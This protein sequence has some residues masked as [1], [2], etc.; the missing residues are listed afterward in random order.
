MRLLTRQQH[1]EDGVMNGSGLMQFGFTVESQ[2]PRIQNAFTLRLEVGIHN[3]HALFVPKVFQCLFL[4]ALP[5]GEMVV[6]ENDHAALGRYV[7]TVATLRRNEAWRAVIPGRPDERFKLF[8]DGHEMLL[9][10]RR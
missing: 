5:I 3:A 4:G 9:P 6:V 8:A 10:L 1:L 7:G 2:E